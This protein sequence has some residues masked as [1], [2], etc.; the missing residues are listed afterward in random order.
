[1]EFLGFWI[2]SRSMT[3]SLPMEKLG[4][5]HNH[6]RS[7]LAQTSVKVREL[8]QFIGRAH[9]ATLA[10]SQAPLF[11]QAL[12]GAKHATLTHKQGLD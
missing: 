9:S 11:Y 5:I 3:V 1:M 6:E 7:L 12:E 10:I 2:D 4:R 8:A